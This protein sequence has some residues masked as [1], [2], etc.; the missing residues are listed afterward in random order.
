MSVYSLASVFPLQLH[1]YG[2][3]L[4]SPSSTYFL[5]FWDVGG[6]PSHSNGRAVFYQQANGE[7]HVQYV[8]HLCHALQTYTVHWCVS[9]VRVCVCVFQL[10][11]P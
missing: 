8:Y 9:D 4:S 11:P 5:E 1:E 2:K 10:L 3:T 6:S 7:L